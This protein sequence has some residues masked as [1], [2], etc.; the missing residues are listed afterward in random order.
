[1]TDIT[2]EDRK[3][4]CQ[5]GSGVSVAYVRERPLRSRRKLSNRGDMEE[6]CRPGSGTI[7]SPLYQAKCITMRPAFMRLTSSLIPAPFLF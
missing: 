1:M 4:F 5:L 6:E 2:L 3:A 7:P